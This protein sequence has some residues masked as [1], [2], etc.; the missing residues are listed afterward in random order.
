MALIRQ[1]EGRVPKH[2]QSLSSCEDRVEWWIKE[3]H[4]EVADQL[5]VTDSLVIPPEIVGVKRLREITP[6]EYQN[7]PKA[8]REFARQQ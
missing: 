3:F 8:K 7:S 1:A 4:R 5:H 2:R 6:A